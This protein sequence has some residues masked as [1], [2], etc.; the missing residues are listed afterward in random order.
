[1]P[2][3]TKKKTEKLLFPEQ[4]NKSYEPAASEAMW[5]ISHY[6]SANCSSHFQLVSRPHLHEPAYSAVKCPSLR[7]EPCWWSGY[8]FSPRKYVACCKWNLPS[9]LQLPLSCDQ[10]E[11]FSPLSP[12]AGESCFSLA[13]RRL[14][15]CQRRVSF[16]PP[17]FT[18]AKKMQSGP[19]HSVDG[20]P[21][22][23]SKSTPN[24]T[25]EVISEWC[26]QR[27]GHGA[28]RRW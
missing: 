15:P 4:D 6:S 24:T 18:K 1:M 5:C 2:G 22:L 11:L 14:V 20:K 23:L 19:F 25:P 26:E 8:W 27:S 3:Q 13:C 17:P 9:D 16:T 21:L 7:L 12:S 28:G 10:Q